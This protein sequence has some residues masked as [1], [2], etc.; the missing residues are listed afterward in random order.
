[1][2][3]LIT[4]ALIGLF[5]AVAPPPPHADCLNTGEA[6][7]CAVDAE[8][9]PARPSY[10]VPSRGGINGKEPYHLLGDGTPV[11]E[12]I[13]CMA[14]PLGLYGQHVTLHGVGTFQCRDHGGAITVRYGRFY[15]AQGF[16]QDWFVAF[17]I[18]APDGTRPEGAYRVV[19]WEVFDE[20]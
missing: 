18:L 4:S 17:D 15:T 12:C 1:M 10:Y 13:D 14:C 16:R 2:T 7:L 3:C 8:T 20:R 19:S 5:C 11:N 6:L 9:L